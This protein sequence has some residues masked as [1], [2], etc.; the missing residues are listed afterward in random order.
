L[1]PPGDG[2]DQQHREIK[3]RGEIGG[4]PGSRWRPRNFI[5][6]AQHAF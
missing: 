3:P 5:K 6:Q 1:R 4:R 2:E